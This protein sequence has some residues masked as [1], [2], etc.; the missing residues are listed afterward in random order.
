MTLHFS[1]AIWKSQNRLDPGFLGLCVQSVMAKCAG[2]VKELE[3]VGDFERG[4]S[5]GRST[6][7]ALTMV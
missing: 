2:A 3:R 1:L 5:P 6:D 7:C 4:G